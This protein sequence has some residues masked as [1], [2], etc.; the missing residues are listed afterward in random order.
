MVGDSGNG[1]HLLY[2]VDFANT[3]ENRELIRQ[4]LATLDQL[5]SND[6]VQV[7]KTTFNP[8]RIVKLYGTK[9]CKGDHIE[10]R[11]SSLVRIVSKRLIY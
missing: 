5:F 7:D 11:P 8:A 3:N 2:S 9:A 6:K 10:E 4:F 1:Y